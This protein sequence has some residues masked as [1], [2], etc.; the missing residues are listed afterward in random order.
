MSHALGAS[1]GNTINTLN[2]GFSYIYEIQIESLK[3][4]DSNDAQCTTYSGFSYTQ[5]KTTIVGTVS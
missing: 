2:L 1:T 3:E 5:V 4:L